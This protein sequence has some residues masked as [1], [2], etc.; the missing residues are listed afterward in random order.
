MKTHLLKFLL[1]FI[2]TLFIGVGWINA[3]NAWI[4]EF[5]YDNDGGDVNEAVE[6][7]VETATVADLSKLVFTLYNGGDQLADNSYDVSTFTAGTPDGG[8]TVYSLLIGSGIQNG[9][10]DGFSLDY[11]GAL[12]QFLSYEGTFTAG[13]G[14]A[15]GILSTDIGVSES[16]STSIGESLQLSGTGSQYSDFTWQVPATATLGTANNSQTIQA[17]VDA[18][19]PVSTWDP[20]TT[21]TGV[22]IDKVITV[23]FDEAIR[24]VSTNADFTDLTVDDLITTFETVIGATGVAFDAT[25]DGTNQ[26]ITITPNADL[27]FDTEY[28]L[29]LAAIEDAE[30]NATTAET[31]TFTTQPDTDKDSKAKDPLLQ[32]PTV[33]IES[34]VT[35]SFPVFAFTISDLATADGLDTKVT[36]ITLTTGPNN[37]FD[38]EG[39]GITD[40]YLISESGTNIPFAGEPVVT[41]SS[42]E[43]PFALDALTIP[44]G[45]DSTYTV[46]LALDTEIE[47]GIIIQFQIVTD[48]HG[49]IA[50]N[51]GSEFAADFAGTDNVIVGNDITI[52]VTATELQFTEQPT[53]TFIGNNLPEV[54]VAA[55]DLNGNTDIDYVTDISITAAGATLNATP[56]AVTPVS[57]ISTFSTLSFSD[58]GNGVTLTAASGVLSN[59]ISDA[60][61]SLGKNLFFS[62]YIEGSG[63]NKAVEIYNGTGVDVDLTDYIVHRFNNG[64]TSN[65]DIDTL[66]GTLINGDV[67]VIYNTGADQ[68]IL[69]EGD[70]GS[71]FTYYNGDDALLLLKGDVVIDVFGNL[72]QDP[73]AAWDVAG[74]TGATAN[75]SLLR[76]TG[77]TY[78][79]T[80]WTSSAGTTEGDSEWI[81][82]GEDYFNN[83]GAYRDVE[84]DTTLSALTTDIGTLAPTF[85]AAI[86]EYTVEL[87]FRT[88]A[89]PK[90]GATASG[91]FATVDT[92]QVTDIFGTEPERT[93]TATVTADDLGTKD[94]TILF[95]IAQG[96][97]NDITGFVFESFDP[98]VTGDLDATAHTVTLTVPYGTIVTALIPTM[99]VS[100]SA[101]VTPLTGV[102]QDFTNPVEYT[103]TAEDGTPQIWTVTVIIE[104]NTENDITSFIFE[105]FEPDAIG[106]LDNAAHTVTA[107]VPFGTDVTAL[108]STIT[109]SSDATISPLSG[110]AQNF[111]SSVTYTVTAED[112]TPQDW[113]VTVN[114]A[115]NDAK[116][117][118]SFGFASLSVDGVISEADSTITLEV[119]FGTDV[120]ALIV[121]FG[122]D[123]SEVKIG[124][125]PQ[126]SGTTPN[127]FTNPVTYIVVAADASEREYEV[128]VNVTAAATDATLSA[129]TTDMG[130]LTP[131]FDAAVI[132]YTVELP[133]GTIDE[134]EVS[135]TENDSK[136]N[137]AI[138]QVSDI[139][140]DETARTATVIVT[141][142]D[143]SETKTY[144]V[145]FSVALNDDATI[146]STEYSVDNGLETITD[147]PFGTTLATF[148]GNLT[149]ATD[150]TFETYESNG[151]TVA[152]D[153][154]TG[155][156]VIV[157][158]QDASNKTYAVTVDAEIAGELFFSEYIEGSSY[159]KAL[160]IYNPTNAS[161]DLTTYIIR[162][163]SN[164]ATDWE[165]DYEFP[166]GSSVAANDVFVIVDDAAVQ[167]ML[168]VADWIDDGY[169]AGFNG[170]DARGLFKIVG[171]DTTLID[172]VGDFNNPDGVD[173][174]V[175]GITAGLA[176][177]TILRKS[178][179]TEGNINW[180]ASAGTN[181]D[182]SEWLVKD[183]DNA[184]NLGLFTVL[185][186]EAY[187]TSTEYTV[188]G[189]DNT[190]TNIPFTATLAEFEANLTPAADATF[191]TYLADGATIATD[192]ATGYKVI[193]TAENNTTTKIY[194]I[195]LNATASDDATVT[196]TVYTVNSTDWTITDV[197]NAT[198][199][200]IFEGNLTPAT[201]ATFETYNAD[202]TTVATDLATGYKVIVTAEDDSKNTYTI[203]LDEAATAILF[204]SEYVEGTAGDDRAFEI[205][206]PNDVSVNLSGFTVKQS[207][208]G[209]GWGIDGGVV[210]I[211][212]VLPLSGTIAAGDVYVVYNSGAASE[213][214][215]V[216]DLALSYGV[217]D[218]S[219]NT[220][221]TGND[222]LGLFR[223]DVLIDVIGVELATTEA[224]PWDVAGTTGAS[225]DHTLIRKLGTTTGNTDWAASAGTSA[226]NSEWI[227]ADVDDITNLGSPTE[228]P[229]NAA[230]VISGF[231]ISPVNPTSNEDVVVKATITD[232]A[233]AADALTVGLFYG[234]ADGSETTSV[235][236]TQVG[237]TDVFEGTIPAS[238]ATVFYKITAND[239]E[240]DATDY[241]GNYSVTVVNGIS[242]PDGIVTMNIFPNPNNGLFTLE[243]NA[244]KAGTFKVEIINI[245]GQIIYS[246]EIHQNGFYKDQIDITKENS[247]VY[248]I[249]L[250]DGN[251]TKVS[252]FMIQ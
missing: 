186:S 234:S 7:V 182:N 100:D 240:L 16:S 157:T 58:E 172:I 4:N 97:E 146:S 19:A 51:S 114:V 181:A 71:T 188:N 107:T 124:A 229:T 136:A 200:A 197:P 239:G 24:D 145:V 104:E 20:L 204:F 28:T 111:T 75:H 12:I 247:G 94:Y 231:E 120:T 187:V 14:P 108:V 42:I 223:D 115:S 52:N 214:S 92:V 77:R 147:I 103:V 93:A 31:I 78:G 199:L 56:V 91:T 243:M 216:G 44:D 50:D 39:N 112:A 37:T 232:D 43:I 36:Q 155:Y 76:K 207:H 72:G 179:I 150:A 218:G 122:T 126:T 59:G 202:G 138:T 183:I 131:V 67:Y 74:I 158:A 159:N 47:D 48:N 11:D 40:G 85:S 236:F 18:T 15:N 87:P 166:V 86:Y 225:Q 208:N 35:D 210:V 98:D 185:N 80:N 33:I 205:Y 161:V 60:F 125:A 142:E 192:L 233:T 180:T 230:P 160:E 46:Y 162:G 215:S 178:N 144:T 191:E 171:N 244:S 32:V 227:V 217:G 169:T 101:T 154:A 9:A 62:E 69:D 170:N 81:I 13:D 137:A 118:T 123:G 113:E 84:H 250:N 110:V 121:T 128:T 88:I 117:I 61:N 165:F 201:A 249:R 130:T 248:Y 220:S 49:F 177:H 95:S 132:A 10:P 26:I 152:T 96:T 224:G 21:S 245:Q 252:K 173:Y 164:G 140:G 106:I 194:T 195:T 184:S 221:F 102:A 65:P 54:I 168:D 66:E 209:D 211:D 27:A 45:E 251:S 135:A 2:L 3:Q 196:S 29:T 203:T 149:P 198:T 175:A 238:D 139:E 22:A 25:I 57:G 174:D 79:N 143:V 6:I 219:K 148:E 163:T 193:V 156:K 153:L 23:T 34:T 213:I 82:M 237:T 68:A 127:D 242:N 226:A 105:S 53:S 133:Y 190:I 167:G 235:T 8:Y 83:L 241:T 99:E 38:F 5:H 73:G 89:T 151:T 246:N 129:L 228:A 63:N 222:A 189:T 176:N 90:V 30:D 41:S 119:P 109:V 134:P 64:A 70:L 212:Y 55:T 141:A 206:N 116:N 1:S 17:A